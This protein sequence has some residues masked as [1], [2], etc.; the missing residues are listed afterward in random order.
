M[1][2][3]VTGLVQ[4]VAR[5]YVT[6]DSGWYINRT[7]DVLASLEAQFGSGT[8][9]DLVDKIGVAYLTFTAST[10]QTIDMLTH[11]VHPITSAAVAFARVRALVITVES[12]TDAATMTVG[13]H[14]TNGWTNLISTGGIILRAAT[15]KNNAGLALIAPNTTGW[16]VSGSNKQLL[17]TPSA[18]VN[19]VRILALGASA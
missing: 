9:L 15:T 7:R 18:H 19:T 10:T 1:A 13:A 3:L 8:A 14:S 11:V 4:A 6:P 16:A 5:G 12:T 17:F 2:D